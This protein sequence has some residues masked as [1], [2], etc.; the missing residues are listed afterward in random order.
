MR[1]SS[2]S[3]SGLKKGA[4]T[5]DEDRLL[6]NCIEKYGE[7]KWHVIPLKAGLNRCR[8]SCR[9]RWL[10]Y[11]RPNI[12]RGDFAEDEID[13]ILRLHKLLG[14]RWALIAGRIP[15]RTANDV[16]N[17]WNT[18]HRSRSKQQKNEPNDTETLQDTRVTIIKPQPQSFSKAMN[19]NP[20]N[21]GHDGGN[22]ESSNN[23]VNNF[24]MSSRLTLPPNVLGDDINRYM[25]DFFDDHGKDIDGNFG[26]SFGGFS[27]EIK[28][29]NTVEQEDDQISL[30]DI[31]MDEV[32]W[33][34]INSEQ[35]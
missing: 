8:K 16:K 23:G 28:A 2:N 24:N 34:L 32:T 5:V 35:Q 20:H 4:W 29:L 27:A 21:V 15:G 22:L 1:P 33:E 14:N 9:L 17:Y 11:L 13:L 26:W 6:K 30:S 31:P 18:R 19:D 12:K 3:A 25:D 10:N 7:G